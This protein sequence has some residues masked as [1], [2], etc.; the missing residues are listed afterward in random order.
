MTE[1]HRLLALAN[2]PNV[3]LAISEVAG[4]RKSVA[5]Y[6]TIYPFDSILFTIGFLTGPLIAMVSFDLQPI[7]LKSRRPWLQLLL[8]IS[9]GALLPLAFVA[10]LIWAWTGTTSPMTIVWCFLGLEAILMVSFRLLAH[11]LW[12]IDFD[13][14]EPYWLDLDRAVHELGLSR[15]FTPP[16][17]TDTSL[18]ELDEWLLKLGTELKAIAHESDT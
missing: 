6:G 10:A 4:V 11:K 13:P 16:V 1:D 5:E 15:D 9:L 2:L 12:D 17:F 14:D 18:D 3:D 7:W 8:N